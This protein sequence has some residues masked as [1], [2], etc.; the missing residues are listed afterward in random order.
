M[1]EQ[2]SKLRI[3]LARNIARKLLRDTGIK[4][5][6]ILIRD[7][8][9]QIKKQRD[10]SVYPWACGSE[11]D[12]IQVTQGNSATIGYNQAKHQHRQRFTVAHEIGH[13]LLGHTSGNFILDLNSKK[14]EDI[15]ANQ[16]A[17]ELLMPLEMLKNSF[18][19]GI[20]NAKDIAR[21]YN[22]SEEMTWWR[23]C[24]C[25]LILKM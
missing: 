25:K 12:G 14:P 21:I 20:K 17:A 13:L 18:Q 9:N 11:I 4:N 22:V 3:G 16:F 5:P 8:V 19:S 7:I 15:E 6:P 2:N 1:D 24:D 10:L 23:L